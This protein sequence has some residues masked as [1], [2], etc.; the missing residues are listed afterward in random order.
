[1]RV[2]RLSPAFFPLWHQGRFSQ[3]LGGDSERMFDNRKMGIVLTVGQAERMTKIKARLL[4]SYKT[5]QEKRSISHENLI[6]CSIR[7]SEKHAM[8]LFF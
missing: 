7:K 3:N 5:S 1:M 2:D 6:F 4:R 8:P